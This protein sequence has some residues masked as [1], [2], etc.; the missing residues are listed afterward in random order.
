MS[1]LQAIGINGIGAFLGNLVSA[2]VIALVAYRFNSKRNGELEAM[3]NDGVSSH[4]MGYNKV[5]FHIIFENKTPVPLR[6]RT[7][8]LMDRRVGHLELNFRRPVSQASLFNALIHKKD[9][10]K[11]PIWA[12]LPF[13]SDDSDTHVLQ[14][15]TGGIWG[16]QKKEIL[17]NEWDIEKCW[18]VVEYPTLFGGSALLKV[19]F[20]QS[21]TELVKSML[22]TIK[23]QA[24]GVGPSVEISEFTQ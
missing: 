13:S 15:Y 18:V 11:I 20:S 17:E 22:A 9:V 16:V 8:A 24:Q 10:P 12:H 4:G 19:Q 3:I 14:A 23:A 5:D 6:V 7:I 21:A 2:A 1:D